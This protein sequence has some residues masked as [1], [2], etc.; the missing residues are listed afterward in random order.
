MSDACCG[1]DE[2][3]HADSDDEHVAAMPPPVW[4]VREFQLSA[5]AGL[6]VL[7]GYLTQWWWS[8]TV[9]TGLFLAGAAIGGSTF[10][11]GAVRSLVR[12]RIGVA[13][14]MTIAMIGALLLG[15]FGEAAMLAFLFSI[16][17]ALEDYSI[18]RTRRGLRALLDLVPDT[19][20]ILS[21]DGDRPATVR[22]GDLRVGDRMLIRPGERVGSDGVVVDGRS[23]LDVSAI[24]GESIPVETG[25][26]DTVFAGSINGRGPL[27]VRASAT[28][29]DNSLARVVAVVEQAQTRKGATARIAD[30]I[31]RPLVPGI[32]ALAAL[33]AGIGALLGDP[34]VW[35]ERALVVLV[36]ASPCALAIS[37]PV[38]VVAAVGAAS[39]TGVLIKGGAALESLGAIRTVALDKTGT[40]TRNAPT[41]TEVVPAADTDR[42]TVLQ[43]A[44]ALEAR[45]E[46]PLA[47]AILSA[48]PV[49]A[50]AADVQTVPGAGITGRVAGRPVRLGR[51]TWVDPG[52]LAG[53]VERL[54]RA[55]S[56]VVV[57]ERDDRPLGLV[58]VRDDLR[59]EAADA[60]RDL[61]GL[62]L[63]VVMLTGDNERTASALAGQAGIDEVHADLRPTG[64]SAI[65]QRLR[66]GSGRVAMVGDGVNDA[67]ALA[68][69]D[70]GIAMG[71]MGSDVAIEAADVALMG[72]DLRHLPDA[73]RQARR[74]RRIMLQN[75]GLSLAIVAVLVPLA[76]F[77]VLG[78][79]A[80]VFL[81]EV[82]EVFVIGNGVRAGH[83]K[84]RVHHRTERIAAP[85]ASAIGTTDR[86]P[87]P[88][89]NPRPAAAG[90][91]AASTGCQDDCCTPAEVA[92]PAPAAGGPE[93]A[94]CG[95]GC[96]CCPQI[97][98]VVQRAGYGRDHRGRRAGFTHPV[99]FSAGGAGEV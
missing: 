86:P 73:L 15:Q 61:R 51:P 89:T 1:P 11:P 49:A 94:A 84:G 37:V 66:F 78:L 31:A 5:A 70:V 99:G 33:V 60:V 69:A 9:A 71:A 98:S 7:A 59:P 45:S 4:R 65:V 55:G 40:L 28:V 26:A 76:G 62:G 74:A 12:G 44:A 27:V 50:A 6:L 92:S 93:P 53:E 34:A 8:S 46:H 72:N 24:T 29:A 83:V 95:E 21:G 38:T 48:V 52:P 64:K 77:G 42:D 14:L 67:P 90:P 96:D 75:V 87:T 82:A 30:R 80:V 41:V 56:T 25:P 20:T 36:A 16:S 35:I 79:A 91:V 85:P 57:V 68:T 58:A 47:A 63:R 88:A 54:Q 17:E 97:S 19:V 10:V 18:S 32:L 23:A 3:G 13:T 81:H 39:R 22:A 2:P 43:V